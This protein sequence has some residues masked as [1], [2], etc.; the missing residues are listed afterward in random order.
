MSEWFV[1]S[2]FVDESPDKEMNKY[3]GGRFIPY[4]YEIMQEHKKVIFLLPYGNACSKSIARTVRVVSRHNAEA[5]AKCWSVCCNS[6]EGLH[7]KMADR[8]EGFY[9]RCVLFRDSD[10]VPLRKG[11]IV[12]NEKMVDLSELSLFFI[13]KRNG[14]VYNTMKYARE[15]GK[16]YI[17]MK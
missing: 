5:V 15:T 7:Q 2:V 11:K 14:R 12:R 13:E 9:E 6:V 17:I 8:T 1:V 3:I 16:E 4:I 10:E